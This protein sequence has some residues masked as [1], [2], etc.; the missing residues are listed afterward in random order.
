MLAG[1]A[2]LAV[3]LER[4]TDWCIDF[5]GGALWLVTPHAWY[6]LLRPA[7][8]FQPLF[9]A[10]RRKFELT[11]RAVTVLAVSPQEGY[12]S[13]LARILSPPAPD[14]DASSSGGDTGAHYSE[15][16]LLQDARFY[17]GALGAAVPA[18]REAGRSNA[19]MARLE[20]HSFGGLPRKRRAGI[21]Y[22]PPPFQPLF[23]EEVVAQRSVL[24]TQRMD[25]RQGT[26]AKRARAARRRQPPP[27]LD[28]SFGVETALVGDVLS[29]WDL[30]SSFGCVLLLRCHRRL[31]TPLPPAQRLPARAAFPA[32][33]P[34]GGAV[35]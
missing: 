1:T 34:G 8:N 4:V 28:S 9:A 21:K 23:E 17:L 29:L 13:M 12:E 7:P 20:D 33:A 15:P 6:R 35:P 5:T 3:V 31:L 26:S 10:T 14:E 22:T 11:L 18:A 30:F 16:V 25:W 32:V 27:P 2:S 19:F 24:L